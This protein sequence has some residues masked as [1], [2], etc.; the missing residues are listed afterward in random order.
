[1]DT[2]TLISPLIIVGLVGFLL[3]KFNWLNKAQ[4]EAITKFAFNIAIPA[5]LFQQRMIS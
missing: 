2:F 5:F 4:V 3:A 1:M